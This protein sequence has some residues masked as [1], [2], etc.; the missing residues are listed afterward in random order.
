MGDRSKSPSIIAKDLKVEGTVHA[1]G[2]LIIAGELEG[3][4]IGDAVVTGEGSRVLARAK[5]Q[6]MVI[7]GEFE[8]NITAH[9]SLKILRTGSLRGNIVCKSL[10]LEA[11][12]RLNGH[13]RPLEP[14]DEV[15]ATDMES[16]AAH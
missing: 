9:E 6:Q 5:V 13:V 7:A 11:G 2:R 15:L 16:P 14:E 1:K 3:T 4:L 10:T 12:G 8:G